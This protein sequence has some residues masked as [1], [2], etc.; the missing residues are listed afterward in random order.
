MVIAIQRCSYEDYQ[1][2]YLIDGLSLRE[3]PEWKADR[4]LQGEKLVAYHFGKEPW[5][6]VVDLAYGSLLG[7]DQVSGCY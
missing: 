1:L 3:A 6:E 7:R 4:M 2:C 5:W